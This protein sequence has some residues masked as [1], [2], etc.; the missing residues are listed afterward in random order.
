MREDIEFDAEGALLR[1][2][3]YPPAGQTPTGNGPAPCVVMAHGWSSTKRMYLDKFA[4]VFAAAGLAVLVFDNRGWGES[5]TAPGKPRHE[6][7]PWLR[8]DAVAEFE[9]LLML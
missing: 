3:F 1:G 9:G 2:W 6:I 7:D 4:D 8:R 5:G